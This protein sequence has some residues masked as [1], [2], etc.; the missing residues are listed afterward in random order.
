MLNI[1]IQENVSL[2]AR[3][4]FCIGGDARFYVEVNSVAELKEALQFAKEK[5]VD[6]YI[7]GS[8]T[9]VLVN[10]K[11]FSG[12]IVKIKMNDISTDETML[13]AAVGVPF[14][15]VINVA[16]EAGLT[17]LESFAG[18][19]GVIGGAVRGNAGAF[20][21]EISE[22]INSVV[23]FDLSKLEPISFSKDECEFSYRSSIFKKNKNLIILSVQFELTQ[24]EKK[25]IEQK[26]KETI[27]KRVGSGLSIFKS[28]GSYFMNPT[29]ENEKLLKEF[30]KDNGG[31]PSK[32]GKLPAGWIID[33]VGLRGKKIGGAMISE[34][35][36]NYIVNTGNATADDVVMLASYVKQHV[37]DQLGIELQEE[38][39]YL[40]F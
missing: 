40:G 25:E 31:V 7:L 35:H 3:T 6:F 1:N 10:D 16:A 8:G 39:E 11:G 14:I 12:I 4:S 30:A 38:V 24:G 18:I 37:R 36:A 28:A 26:I 2:A 34:Q 20:S 23:A 22:Y 33:H 21:K 13:K 9:N 29:V 15:K 19:P 5:N 27:E 32:N 17:G